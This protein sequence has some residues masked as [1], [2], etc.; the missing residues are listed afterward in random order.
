LRGD[1]LKD[2]HATEQVIFVMKGGQVMKGPVR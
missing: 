1:P 2:I